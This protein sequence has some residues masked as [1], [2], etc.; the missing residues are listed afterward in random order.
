MKKQIFILLLIAAFASCKSVKQIGTLNMLSTRNINTTF[1][2]KL[3]SSYSNASKSDLK[4]NR[5]T[6]IDEAINNTVKNTPGGE[7][8]MN[9]KI[10]KIGKSKYAVS[11]DV[12]G[13]SDKKEISHNGFFVG[14][15]VRY[16]TLFM[17]EKAVI[18]SLKNSEKC[19]IKI[20]GTDILKEVA[21]TT[22]TKI[23]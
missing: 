15:K 1:E 21:Y 22:I 6:T 3:L 2:Y 4:K 11:G 14:N 5:F 17:D 9:V 20:D 10:Y 18:V 19:I 7:F 12:W 23:E 13:S 8:L 16:K